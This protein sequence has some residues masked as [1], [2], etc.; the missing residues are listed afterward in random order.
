MKSLLFV[1]GLLCIVGC[2]PA[3]DNIRIVTGTGQTVNMPG[4]WVPRE[5]LRDTVLKVVCYKP[6]GFDNID[7]V[8][9]CVSYGR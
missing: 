8:M 1:L 6:N 5:V 3:P 2:Q 9:S 4:V 7:A